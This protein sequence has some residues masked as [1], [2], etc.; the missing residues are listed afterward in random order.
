MISDALKTNSTLETLNLGRDEKK[1]KRK[2]SIVTYFNLSR[3]S[4]LDFKMNE[5]PI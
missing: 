5:Y 3:F 2:N 1:R 4:L